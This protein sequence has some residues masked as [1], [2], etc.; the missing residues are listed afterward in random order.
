[1]TPTEKAIAQIEAHELSV[2][3][4]TR[5]SKSASLLAANDLIVSK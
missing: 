3:Y 5:L 4:V 1:M 2:R